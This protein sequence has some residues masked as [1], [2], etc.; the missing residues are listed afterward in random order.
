MTIL[1]CR[2]SGGGYGG[3]GVKRWQTT[4]N[5]TQPF[6]GFCSNIRKPY[7]PQAQ[8]WAYCRCPLGM[9]P[10]GLPVTSYHS[11]KRGAVLPLSDRTS[12]PWHSHMWSST[13]VPGFCRCLGHS[14]RQYHA[15]RSRKHAGYDHVTPM[16]ICQI[17]KPGMPR[18]PFLGTMV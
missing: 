6:T 8:V 17:G 5:H 15:Q 12:G 18:A 4:L 3:D 13:T 2:S 16:G 9:S 11:D 10:H 14:F 1:L 7:A